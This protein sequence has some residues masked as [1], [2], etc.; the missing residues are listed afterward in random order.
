MRDAALRLIG[1][2]SDEDYRIATALERVGT[3]LRDSIGFLA[4]GSWPL[5]RLAAILWADSADIPDELGTALAR[6][7]DVR[8]RIASAHALVKAI[9]RQDSAARDILLN[10]PRWSVRSLFTDARV[11]S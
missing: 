4:Q 7:A 3:D 9:H 5:R 10:D 6:D 1:V 8:V 2:G 11:N